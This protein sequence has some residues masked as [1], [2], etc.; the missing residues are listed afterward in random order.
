MAGV[1]EDGST[2]QWGQWGTLGEPTGPDQYHD[3]EET[4]KEEK[5]VKSF[6]ISSSG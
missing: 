4:L 3:E 2:H 6:K 1:A 5:L